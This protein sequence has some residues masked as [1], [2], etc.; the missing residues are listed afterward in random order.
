MIFTILNDFENHHLTFFILY[1]DQA[2]ERLLAGEEVGVDLPERRLRRVDL[3]AEGIRPR[4]RVPR[5]RAKGE[6]G[7]ADYRERQMCFYTSTEM[8]VNCIFSVQLRAKL[9]PEYE[10]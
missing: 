3:L 9:C 10:L 1:V 4:V 6:G 5:P 7:R 8:R 2:C